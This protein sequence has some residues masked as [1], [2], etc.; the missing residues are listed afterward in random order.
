[1]VNFPTHIPYCG[2]HSP[3][4]LDLFLSSDAN[5]CST[6]AFPP[7]GNSNH[8]VVKFSINFTANSKWYF[9]YHC[10]VTSEFCVCVQ[11]GI[12]V[13]ISHHK[14]QVKPHSSLWFS[15][16]CAAAL[17]YRN[18]FFHLHQQNK[19]SESKGKFMLLIVGKG[20]LKLLNLH[21]SLE[22]KSTS[23]PRNLALKTFGELPS[24]LNKGKS[25]ISP[26]FNSLEV[27]SSA[28][29]KATLLKTFLRTLILMT[30]VSLCLVSLLELI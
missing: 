20:F 25:A 7:L 16:A 4:L 8:V 19:S 3:A 12:N 26:L 21:M 14:Y 13:Y 22:Q 5:I 10:I 15:A 17:V 24:V 1:M 2:S 18:H 11:V 28:S 23:C 27:L 9:L 30:Q 29:D 6:M